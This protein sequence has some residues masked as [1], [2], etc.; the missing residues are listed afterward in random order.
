MTP[1]RDR[2]PWRPGAYSPRRTPTRRQVAETIEA[3]LDTFDRGPGSAPPSTF[4]PCP[5][6]GHGVLT[7]W[8][9]D[10]QRRF[11]CILAAGATF[12]DQLVEC[13]CP[14]GAFVPPTRRRG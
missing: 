12:P 13:D 8:F 4:T 7:H 2:P 5:L 6:C 14:G 11:G 1:K 10:Y 9:S 3:L